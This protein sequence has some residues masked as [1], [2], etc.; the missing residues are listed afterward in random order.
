MKCDLSKITIKCVKL[1]TVLWRRSPWCT[2]YIHC[3]QGRRMVWKSGGA[4]SNVVGIICP[5]CLTY[6]PK[7]GGV[8]APSAIPGWLACF[9]LLKYV[10][11]NMW[12]SNWISKKSNLNCTI[13]KILP[14]TNPQLFF[15]SKFILW[16]FLNRIQKSEPS[17]RRAGTIECKMIERWHK[18]GE[19]AGFCEFS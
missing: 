19:A 6:L 1:I 10:S 9:R 16:M 8:M 17:V 4:N 2:V 14:I 18:S 7:S 11:H 13:I 5:S 15:A 3:L 12:M